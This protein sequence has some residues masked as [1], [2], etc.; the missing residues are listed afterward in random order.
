MAIDPRGRA[1]DDDAKACVGD[2]RVDASPPFRRRTLVGLLVVVAM[3]SAVLLAVRE[4]RRERAL[5]LS[6]LAGDARLQIQEIRITAGRKHVVVKSRSAM[7]YL[8]EQFRH[9]QDDDWVSGA[10]ECTLSL[11]FVPDDVVDVGMLV[12]EN[13]WGLQIDRGIEPGWPSRDVILLEPQPQQIRAMM[14]FLLA[15]DLPSDK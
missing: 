5:L 15:D 14:E 3:A 2:W 12:S 11:T 7:D 10:R 4:S 1:I 6:L 9:G 8:T 13:R